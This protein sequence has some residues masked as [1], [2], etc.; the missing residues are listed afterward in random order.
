MHETISLSI[1][2]SYSYLCLWQCLICKIHRKSH[3]ILLKLDSESQEMWDNWLS[4]I[5]TAVV[6]WSQIII[7]AVKVVW[8]QIRITVVEVVW[9]KSK[10]IAVVVWS[11]NLTT[12]VTVVWSQLKITVFEV[13]WSQM[14]ITAVEKVWSQMILY[15]NSRNQTNKKGVNKNRVGFTIQFVV[16]IIAIFFM[17][18]QL[19]GQ[20]LCV[21]VDCITAISCNPII[22]REARCPSTCLSPHN[23]PSKQNMDIY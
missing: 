9:N 23:M 18:L 10:I 1:W 4:Q 15:E 12:A 22:L 3:I 5:I 2:N 20:F 19:N 11:Q 13:V 17:W 14:M 16:C 7:T 21:V 6:V 8:S